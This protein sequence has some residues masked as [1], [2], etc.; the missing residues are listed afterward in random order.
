MRRLPVSVGMRRERNMIYTVK[1]DVKEIGNRIVE[2]KVRN[3]VVRV[4][5]PK[6]FGADDTAPTPPEMLAISLG[7]CVVSTI[8]FIAA[9]KN[10]DV[11][12][13][14]VSVEGSID[15]SRAM[16]VSDRERA[17][18]GALKVGIRFDSGMASREK[19]DFIKT[20]FECGASID[21]IRNATPVTCE[22]L[23]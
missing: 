7:S 16:G 18:F 23:E 10:L 6:E 12:N 11:G 1:V 13:I 22:I 21:N 15:F 17:G 3:H 20:V 4:D 19:E 5:Q 8:Q 9:Q 2:C 14:E